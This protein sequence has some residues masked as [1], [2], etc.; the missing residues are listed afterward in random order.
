VIPRYFAILRRA[1]ERRGDRALLDA[2][3]DAAQRA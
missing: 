3:D 2:L 1:A